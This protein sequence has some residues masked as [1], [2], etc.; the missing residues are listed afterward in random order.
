M[1]IHFDSVTWSHARFVHVRV[2]SIILII[3]THI[4]R[5]Y[6]RDIV[7]EE[8]LQLHYSL[9]LEINIIAMHIFSKFDTINQNFPYIF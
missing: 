5:V 9:Q 3:K 1:I 7:I 8:Y 4:M 2:Y 6:F